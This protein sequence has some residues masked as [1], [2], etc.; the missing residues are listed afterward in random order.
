MHSTRTNWFLLKWCILYGEGVVDI[1]DYFRSYRTF[2]FIY[3]GGVF[4]D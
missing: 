3:V 2:R 4:I 1:G